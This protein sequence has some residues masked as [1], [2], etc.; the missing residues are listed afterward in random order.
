MPQGERFGAPVARWRGNKQGFARPAIVNQGARQHQ[1]V[2]GIVGVRA[3]R[4][5]KVFHPGAIISAAAVD[6]AKQMMR[7]GAADP[8][9]DMRRAVEIAALK[10]G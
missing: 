6:K 7:L 3:G 1:L 5:T 8:P 10:C 4:S 9:R 2:G